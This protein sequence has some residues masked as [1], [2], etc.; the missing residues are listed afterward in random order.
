[1]RRYAILLVSMVFLL[2]TVYFNILFDYA[3][4]FGLMILAL[5]LGNFVSFRLKKADALIVKLALG[6]GGIG[7]FVW[8][9]TFYNVNHKSLFIVF[10]IFLMVFQYRHVSQDV[11][12]IYDTVRT[13]IQTHTLLLVLVISGII[14]YTIP[15]SYPITQWDSL[16]K[17][18]VIP[19]QIWSHGYYD[20]NVVESIIFGDYALLS[21]ML[22]FFLMTFGGVKALVLLNV[23]ISLVTL[24]AILRISS[25][26][27]TRQLPLYCITLLYFTTPL[28]YTYSTI[29]NVDLYPVFFIAVSLVLLRY[30]HV[31]QILKNLPVIALLCGF[32]FFAKQ[33]A[34]YLIVPM[35][36]YILGVIA[37]N[38][39]RITLVHIGR[40]VLSIVLFFVP[41]VP[42]MG[43]IW[44]KT[45][46]PLFPFLNTFFQSPY[47]ALVNFQDPYL[48][49]KRFLGFD[50]TSLYS[51]VFHTSRNTEYI[52][53]GV[54]F[55]LLLIP[56]AIVVWLFF[57]RNKY[58][59]LLMLMSLG[60][61]WVS[62]TF[63][64]PNI[65]YFLGAIL[66]AIPLVVLASEKLILKLKWSGV[67]SAL[68]VLAVSIATIEN[69]HL[70][71]KTKNGLGF[72]A[73]MLYPNDKLTRSSTEIEL[74]L[75]SI[76]DPNI[77]LLSNNEALRGVYK[78][79]FYTLT[80]Y[81]SMLVRRLDDK[82]LSQSEL[83]QNFDYYLVNKQ[84]PLMAFD[85]TIYKDPGYL[86]LP[87]QDP[88]VAEMLEMVKENALYVLYKIKKKYIPIVQEEFQNA[89]S[90]DVASPRVIS[91]ERTSMQSSYRISLDVA[92]SDV[93]KET[94]GRFQINWLNKD[95]K[96]IS[97]SIVPF[98]LSK[99]R[100]VYEQEITD[101]PANAAFG[102]LYLTSHSSD[103]MEV[104]G[105]RLQSHGG[106]SFIENELRAYGQKLMPTYQ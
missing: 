44:Y 33:V 52:D 38:Y 70:L 57:W 66:F 91:F 84:L 46:N 27:S 35:A 17:H 65:R 105:Y 11:K 58:V 43:V 5:A 67:F 7:F 4:V 15:A 68:L 53:K 9:T 37:V 14:F 13:L 69:V 40:V 32:A 49:W 102:H 103:K 104:F 6:L 62:V 29:L 23:V 63:F 88:R 19:F 106:R 95:G 51:I 55:H 59:F 87:P 85:P 86:I 71:L 61:Y 20:Y 78:G 76:N 83:L 50:F 16:A 41:F 36:F 18:I 10:A 94:S 98:L 21:H 39:K 89:L 79:H 93:K 75:E 54:G 42:A 30:T 77:Y 82:E 97:A 74:F 45:G 1:M 90:V 99:Q 8:L 100:A 80:W 47:F 3:L 12:Y 56:L 22:Y 101:I 73:D 81:N 96:F 72:K 2:E 28:I 92:P 25:V 48:R 64:N 60:S 26:L 31:L 24:I 34:F